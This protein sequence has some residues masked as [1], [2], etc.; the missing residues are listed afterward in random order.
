MNYF[1]FS[2]CKWLDSLIDKEI[3]CMFRP[4]EITN[5]SNLC[6]HTQTTR[7]WTLKECITQYSAQGIHGISVWRHLLEDISVTR[8]KQILD[9]HG[10]Q[11]VSLVRGGFFPSVNRTERKQS[12]RENISAIEEAA[13][14]GSPLLVLVCGADPGQ[15]QHRSREQIEEGIREILPAAERAGVKLAIEPLHPMY[16]ADRSAITTMKQANDMN[17]RISSDFLGVAVD[18][19]HLWWDP[20]LQDEIRRCGEMKKLFAFHLCD[21]KVPMTDMLNDRGLMGDGC[22]ELKQ[23][24]GWMEEAGFA[25][26]HEVE[27]FSHKYWAMDQN[28]YLNKIAEAYLKYT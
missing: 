26:F 15:S 12:I 20:A 3:H 14:L 18:V 24:R 16:A 21:W 6:V 23:I 28:D 4:K 8:S 27:I 13:A 1:G 17:E 2:R 5:L 7:P 10:M 22:I 9:D 25:G 11:V 19:F